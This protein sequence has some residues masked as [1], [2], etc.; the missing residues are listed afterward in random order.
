MSET[1]QRPEP[2]DL[3]KYEEGRRNFPP[4]ELAK[5]A[6]KY[7]AFSPD[8][9]RVLASGETMEA[10]EQELEAAGIVPSQV[11]GSYVLP[12]DTVLLY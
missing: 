5:Y 3:S 8:G 4:E 2:P 10:V 11:V 9:T 1:N 7:I 12:P 6:G